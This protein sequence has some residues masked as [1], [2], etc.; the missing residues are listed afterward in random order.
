M[1]WRGGVSAHV[2]IIASVSASRV[3]CLL[4]LRFAVLWLGYC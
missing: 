1:S 4:A 3:E 2:C